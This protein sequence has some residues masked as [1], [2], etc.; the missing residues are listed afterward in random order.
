[1]GLIQR[2]KCYDKLNFI[3]IGTLNHKRRDYDGLLD[4]FER[5]FDSGTKKFTLTLL[6]APVDRRGFQLIDRCKTLMEK[7]LDINYYTEYI[8]EDVVN[9]KILS[10]D[11]IINPNYVDM[12]GRGTFGAIV[13]AMQFAK[14]GIYPANSLHHEELIS[15]SLIYNNIEELPGIIE[16]LLINPENLKKLSQNALINSEKFSFKAVAKKFQES[17]LKSHLT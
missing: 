17:V 13:K 11:V 6:G 2:P 8:H 10:A 5:L 4:A 12:Y 14:P 9:E 7:G 15:S 16:D 1:L 3:T